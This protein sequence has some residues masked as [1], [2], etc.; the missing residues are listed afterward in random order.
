[1]D[2][3]GIIDPD[4]FIQ[5]KELKMEF[6]RFD[7]DRDGCI[8]TE[9]KFRG[10]AKYDAMPSLGTALAGRRKL[11]GPEDRPPPVA[12]TPRTE[13][14]NRGPES[15]PRL[16]LRDCVRFNSPGGCPNGPDC[17]FDHVKRGLRVRHSGEVLIT[18]V[19]AD[20]PFGRVL[21]Y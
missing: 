15:M 4:E 10:L 21:H 16:S 1:M 6:R 14:R 17:L 5:V 12:Q 11:P 2:G 19:T 20:Q 9:E 7:T 18:E 13:T 8:T 3:D